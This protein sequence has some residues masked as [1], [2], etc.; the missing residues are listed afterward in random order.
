MKLVPVETKDLIGC[1]LDWAVGE[2]VDEWVE[3]PYHMRRSDGRI[4]SNNHS[5]GYCPSTDWKQGGPLIHQHRVEIA[6]FGEQVRACVQVVTKH[7]D[8]YTT[9]VYILF[10]GDPAATLVVAMRAVVQKVL[11][12]TVSVP[13]ELMEVAV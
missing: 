10:Y 1:A 6:Y 4:W 9:P 8:I 13:T 2:A 11:G 5:Y 7:S 12:S 3:E